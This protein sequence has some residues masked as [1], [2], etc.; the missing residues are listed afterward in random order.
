[1][2]FAIIYSKK[3]IAG[4]NIVNQFKE[5]AFSPQIPIIELKNE[6]ILTNIFKKDFPELKDIDF[7]VYASQ[8]RSKDNKPALCLHAPGNWRNAGFGGK[9]GIVCLTSAFVLKYLFQQLNKN[10]SNLTDYVISLEATHHGPVTDIPCCFI[11]LGATEKEFNDKLAAIVIAKTIFSL[12]NFKKQEDWIPS[13]A[14]GGGHYNQNFN[15]IQQ[16][17]K[18][19]ISHI[20]PTY[21]F[22]L[23]ESILK[24]AENKTK[25]QVQTI[26]IDWKSLKAEQRDS[27]LEIIKKL[28]LS[29]EKTTNIEK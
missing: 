8:H 19:A 11:E 28:N 12:Q 14:L 7:L 23:T 1:M 24:E 22:P 6:T 13:I 9:D 16:N 2:R 29:Y 4:T 15:K 17:S 21:A 25:E 3:D 18:Y 10:A 26:L 5:L 27:A 20:I